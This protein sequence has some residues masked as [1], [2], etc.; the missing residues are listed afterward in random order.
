M[1]IGCDNRNMVKTKK[2]YIFC[3][4]IFLFIVFALAIYNI[5]SSLSVDELEEGSRVM[6]NSELFYYLNIGYDGKDK[7]ATLSSNT[8][9]AEVRSDYIYVEDK[10][11]EGLTFEEFVTTSDGTIGAVQKG[12]NSK[13]CTGY[14]VDGT[15]GLH[16]DST[17][18]TVSFKIK[19]L[20][21]GCQITVGIKTR[22]PSTNPKTR[23][24]F[25]NTAFGREGDS[26][27]GSNTVHVFMGNED[28]TL[29]KVKYVYT[30]TVPSNAPTLPKE[31]SYASGTSVGVL[32]NVEVAGYTFSG[33]KSSTGAES[34]TI[35]SGKFT[36]PAH[37]VTI[38]GSFTKNNTYKVTY[39]ISGEKPS[40][41]MPPKE[42]QYEQGE[43]VIIDSLKAGDIVDGYKFLG[44]TISD[45]SVQVEEGEEGKAFVMPDRNVTIT[46]NFERIKYKVTYQF[47]GS[48]FPTN[49][50]SL[51][52][53]INSYYPG[54]TVTLA[55][56]PV[57]SGYKFLGWYKAS[58]FTMPEEDVIIYGEW[59][60]E[61]GTFSP[62]ITKTIAGGKKTYYHSGDVIQFTITVTNPASFAIKDVIVKE[63]NADTKFIAGT[64]YTVLNNSMV[65]IT[66]IDAGKSVSVTAEY[67][68]GNSVVA[69]IVNG[70]TLTGAL[71]DNDY[72]LDTTKQY[73]SEVDFNIS[74]LDLKVHVIG[75]NSEELPY[76]EFDLC[77]DSNCNSVVSGDKLSYKNLNPGTKYYLKQKKAQSGYTLQK[78]VIEVTIDE[79][80]NFT[81]PGYQ[82][83]QEGGHAEFTVMCPKI[84]ILPET[85]GMGIVPFIISGLVLMIGSAGGCIYFMKKKNGEGKNDK[86]N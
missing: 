20:Q 84:N 42:K 16:Y 40:G 28:E 7:E 8:A 45:S 58:S 82:V 46:G 12:N 41:Y 70:V 44:W 25:Y 29:Y 52:P 10:I 30:G 54:E 14:V 43:D 80:G 50:D 39:S 38:E 73:H 1:K 49:V 65:S 34:V 67:S 55:A 4:S 81:V 51:L 57:A 86:K 68:V 61:A 56:D 74:N 31:S 3:L 2:K 21:A 5:G 27:I 22:T 9:T 26:S 13:P 63:E 64:G 33:W 47:Q 15:S 6:E 24:D 18:R 66:T 37:N 75:P 69:H 59:M 32:A 79:N 62:T 83:Q 60:K 72:H 11:P 36:M 71:A 19:N 78:N 48:V 23:M 76:A 85:G 17:T 35:T 77:M 53:P